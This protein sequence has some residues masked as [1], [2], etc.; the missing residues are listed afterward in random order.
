MRVTKLIP[1]QSAIL[2]FLALCFVTTHNQK[3]IYVDS[4][5]LNVVMVGNIGVSQDESSIKKDVLDTIKK[6]HEY[7]P[8]HLGINPGNNVYPQGS[9]VNDFQKLNEVFTTE[10]PSDIY[11]F[12][13]LTVL[14]KNDH[15]GDFETQIQYHHLV[16]TRFYLPKRNYVYDVTLN[17]GTQI[18]FMCIDSTSI[19][20]PG[21][22]TPDDRL[23]QLQNFNDVLDNSRQFDH[24]FLILNHNVVNGCGSD[25]EIPNDQPFYKIVLHD[26]LTAILTG[27]DY[28]MQ[29]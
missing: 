24:V 2:I 14:G 4:V 9:Q 25:V 23:I 29:V 5:Q 8:F 16:D 7:Q 15:D 18:R 1:P 19:Y 11:Q 6:I 10:F 20:E 13:F 17:D 26:A 21:M 3:Q 27:Y 12:D 22:M 28:Y